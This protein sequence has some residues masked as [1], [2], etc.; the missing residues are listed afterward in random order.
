MR[1]S[2]TFIKTL[3]EAPK[4]E[5]AKNGAL[6]TRAGYI[7]KEMAG[8]YDYLPLGL[9]VIENI[10]TIIREELNKLGCE[11][12]LLSALQNPELWEKTGRFSDSE[13]D[14]WFKTELSAGGVLGLAPTHEEPL[15]NMLRTYVSSY[16]DLPLYIYQFQTKFRNELRAKSGI[17][18]GREF[19]MKDLYSFHTSE[20]DLDKFYDEVEKA[21]GRIFD[22]LGIGDSTF[23]TFASGGIFAKYSHEFQTFLPVGEDTV[24][25]NNDKS[26][27]LNEEVLNDEVMAD[28]GVSR[29]E[30]TET[31]AAEVGNIFKLKFKYS[32]PLG[33]KF[34]DESNTQQN[35]YMGCYG[36]GVSRLMGVIAEMFADEKGLVWPESIAPFKYYLVGIGDEG[37]KKAEEFYEKHEEEIL[38]DDRDLRPGEKFA[39][40]ELIG[41]PYRVVISGKTLEN[42]SAELTDRRT[43]E[44][45]L[46]SLEDLEK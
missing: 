44:T 19:L 36:I 12:V 37:M 30:L 42:G 38:F 22:R 28:L 24:Y 9:R 26:I 25:Y 8:V 45:K 16:K 6:L 41:I 31:T 17:L 27:V 43:G 11:E 10:K 33:L 35:V 23:E 4:D 32:E 1:F 40:S 15:T 29:E 39:D 7:H 13:V 46:V 2:K 34:V 5:T 21:Y 20:E 18:R 3:R 14:I